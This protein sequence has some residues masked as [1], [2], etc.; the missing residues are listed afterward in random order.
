MLQDSE[1]CLQAWMEVLVNVLKLFEQLPDSQ[2]QA[3]L[4]AAFSCFN[5]LVCY[6][7]HGPLREALSHWVHHIG[8]L[9]GLS[10]HG[11]ARPTSRLK[12]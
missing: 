3:L 4:P 11:M 9:Y 12:K 1:A 7:K 10:P 8:C 6:S 2:Y 5:Q